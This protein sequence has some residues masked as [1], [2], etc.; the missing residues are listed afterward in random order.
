MKLRD[1][2]ALTFCPLVARLFLAAS[3]L[4]FGFGKFRVMEFTG[5]NARILIDLG[6]AKSNHAGA[7]GAGGGAAEN[8]LPESR[9]EP[10]GRL[11]LFA[12]QRTVGFAAF[13][14][15]D[16]AEET[17]GDQSQ[18]TGVGTGNDMGDNEPQG[19]SGGG[20]DG[21]GSGDVSASP[22][23]ANGEVESVRV[24]GFHSITIM[25]Y[26]AGN[27]H[28]VW[29]ARLAVVT[30]VVGGLMMLIGLFTRLFGLGL[31]VVM[32]FAFYLTTWQTLSGMVDPSVTG[33]VSR[34]WHGLT[35]FGKIGFGDQ[36]SVFNQ[37][38]HFGLAVIV[39]SMGAGKISVDHL[40]FGSR[41]GGSARSREDDIAIIGG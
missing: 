13:G 14:I 29:M 39:L 15:Q 3:F 25:L 16:E 34:V 31:A 37:L 32:C 8:L 41:S 18:E 35:S 2:F 23:S 22:P 10:V 36:I 19:E 20:G 11:G 17:A 26:R 5:E 24:Y 40:L 6:V 12:L 28:P 1:R 38:A 27:T 21:E 9:G 33:G 7:N 4:W 30:E